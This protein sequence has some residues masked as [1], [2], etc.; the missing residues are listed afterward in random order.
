MTTVLVHLEGQGK[1]RR[2][3]KPMTNAVIRE[4]RAGR[5]KNS[6]SCVAEVCI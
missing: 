6:N 4:C 3:A 5:V 2:A 1:N